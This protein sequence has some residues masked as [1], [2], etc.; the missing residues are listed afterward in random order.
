MGHFV[1]VVVWCCRKLRWCKRNDSGD[2][3][4]SEGVEPSKSIFSACGMVPLRMREDEYSFMRSS[5]MY[6]Q[7]F[8]GTLHIYTNSMAESNLDPTSPTTYTTPEGTEMVL[9]DDQCAILDQFQRFA[10]CTRLSKRSKSAISLVRPDVQLVC[11]G[12]GDS[13]KNFRKV[14]G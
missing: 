3:L 12:N 11:N 13:L 1:E 6:P 5:V 10:C 4:V 7:D 8:M 9:D 14:S 2:D